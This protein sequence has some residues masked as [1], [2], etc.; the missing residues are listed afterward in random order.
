V[1]LYL[2]R[3]A[4]FTC[5]DVLNALLLR[6]IH[7]SIQTVLPTRWN[8]DSLSRCEQRLINRRGYFAIKF[9]I[10]SLAFLST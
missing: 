3:A 6:I 7:S 2:R 4:S 10:K 1:D 8:S 5:K 9:T